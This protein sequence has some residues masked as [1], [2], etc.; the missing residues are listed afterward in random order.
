MQQKV[1]FTICICFISS[2]FVLGQE[3]DLK[4]A[5]KK[6]KESG[7]A[8]YIARPS[9]LPVEKYTQW[10]NNQSEYKIINLKTEERLSF[11][12]NTN[13]VSEISFIP[14][15][16]LEAYEKASAK[17]ISERIKVRRKY[18]DYRITDLDEEGVAESTI[19]SYFRPCEGCGL[20][21]K[22]VKDFDN[23]TL[24]E[25]ISVF[26]E[27]NNK[28]FHTAAL[29]NMKLR[30]YLK[31]FGFTKQAKEFCLRPQNSLSGISLKDFIE[32]TRDTATSIQ[33][34]YNVFNKLNSGINVLDKINRAFS[35]DGSY[36]FDLTAGDIETFLEISP[37]YYSVEQ[38]V[39]DGIV[40]YTFNLN[41]KWVSD[42]SSLLEG[43]ISTQRI[44]DYLK[45]RE[46]ILAQEEI[47]RQQRLAKWREEQCDNCKID[48]RESN[49]PHFEKDFNPFAAM[50]GGE[51][52]IQK[53]GKMVMKN[54]DKY[55]FY[56]D[57]KG[58]FCLGGVDWLN[59]TKDFDS[60]DNMI[61][62]F[63]QECQK[64]YC[65]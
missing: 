65:K 12:R 38:Y 63:I 2:F 22:H 64:K 24:E 31:L 26:P 3:G 16:E 56:I 52:T 30:A 28:F 41:L 8:Y 35:L 27:Y 32:L 36:G 7:N 62:S 1:I 39:I 55:E 15:T 34:V 53:P 19:K 42:I 23:F 6:G 54:G 14:L 60:F 25:F 48:E 50:L 13:C 61:T 4:K 37:D 46:E 10:A 44:K 9:N 17:L 29:E 45:I 59:K 5:I 43:H 47:R 33:I 11:G 57:D 18:P 49:F 21:Q 40:N 51:Y 20:R 58:K